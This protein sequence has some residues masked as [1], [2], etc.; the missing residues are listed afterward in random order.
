M[1]VLASYLT[2][3][4]VLECAV[5]VTLACKALNDWLDWRTQ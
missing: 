1:S 3:L 5:I 4:L 2:V